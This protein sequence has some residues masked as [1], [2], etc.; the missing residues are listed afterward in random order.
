MI[1]TV[2]RLETIDHLCSAL[3]DLPTKSDAQVGQMI[4]IGLEEI[5]ERVGAARWAKMKELV[6]SFVESAIKA[7]AGPRDVFL[8]VEDGSYVIVFQG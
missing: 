4:A 1:M 7:H 3:Q 8:R 5:E 6:S 2:Q